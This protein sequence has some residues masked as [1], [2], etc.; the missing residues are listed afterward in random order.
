[1]GKKA[2]M[3]VLTGSGKCATTHKRFSQAADL[4]CA[5]KNNWSS[6]MT[7]RELLYQGFDSTTQFI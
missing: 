2:Q 7:A 3:T 4:G 6:M 1:M 5:E